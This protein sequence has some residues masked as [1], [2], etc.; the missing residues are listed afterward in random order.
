MLDDATVDRV[1]DVPADATLRDAAV[2]MRDSGVGM[3]VVRDQG[4]CVG[5]VTDRDLVVRGLASGASATATV[6]GVMTAPPE[7][8]RS[9]ASIEE[10]LAVMAA[11][12]HR[13]L[14]VTNGDGD[15]IGVVSVT[16]LAVEVDHLVHGLATVM[17]GDPI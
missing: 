16:D 9:D 2:R 6:A 11:T 5:V 17:H 14:L 1:E 7:S 3:L 4:R 10:A 13:R 15:A 8:I 12:G